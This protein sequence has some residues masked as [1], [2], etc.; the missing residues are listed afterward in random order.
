MFLGEQTTRCLISFYISFIKISEVALLLHSHG[1][2]KMVDGKADIILVD[3][4]SNL[5]L[6]VGR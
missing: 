6:G 1:F 3:E 2:R 4:S 5:L